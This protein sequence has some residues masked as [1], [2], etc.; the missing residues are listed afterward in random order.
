MNH[1][2]VEM[3][4][5]ILSYVSFKDLLRVSE[6]SKCLYSIA[7]DPDLWSNFSFYS[8][9]LQNSLTYY[10][11]PEKYREINL[12]TSIDKVLNLKIFKK[13]RIIRTSDLLAFT[14]MNSKEKFD[15]VLESLQ[16][17]NL[18]EFVLGY[19]PFGFDMDLLTNITARSKII[20]IHGDI[21]YEFVNQVF[22]Q[23]KS[24]AIEEIHIQYPARINLSPVDPILLGKGINKLKKFSFETCNKHL[25][26]C[27]KHLTYFSEQQE[28]EI[29]QQMASNS[30]LKYLSILSPLSGD[31]QP[32]LLGKAVNNLV[33]LQIAL[34]NGEQFDSII[35]QLVEF[36]N[37]ETF[38]CQP[39][40]K[41]T[42]SM[43]KP[44]VI[45]TGINKLKK[46]K[47]ENSLIFNDS[48]LFS[49]LE[50]AGESTSRLETFDY[51][52]ERTLIGCNYYNWSYE[53]FTYNNIPGRNYESYESNTHVPSNLS[54][55]AIKIISQR[56]SE[57]FYKKCIYR[58]Y[59]CSQVT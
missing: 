8:L 20:T 11:P 49:I 22:Q 23:Q 46:F 59:P 12:Q 43:L 25:T 7:K 1:L 41:I 53:T 57:N 5:H 34:D 2:P 32:S 40:S 17:K 26:Y 21:S 48:Q 19:Q 56:F 39:F 36:S 16:D 28:Q 27:N 55:H 3:I 30:Y 15:K 45:S 14:G 37:L 6:T 47:C 54:K 10:S 29:F 31:L 58:K 42:R 44:N 52:Q 38:I 24:D 18:D 35:K 50:L 13:L 4:M 33:F 51:H 9:S